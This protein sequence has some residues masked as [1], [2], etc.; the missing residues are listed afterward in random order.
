M[1]C[2]L[3]DVGAASRTRVRRQESA[4][5]QQTGDGGTR[6]GEET[7]GAGALG[8]RATLVQFSSAFCQPCR[9]T[10]RI[11]R[12]VSGM[13][14]GVAHAEIDA[15]E[16]L[17]L[18]RELGIVRTPAVLVLDAGGREVSR[19]YGQP[20]K[21]DVIAALAPAVE[22]GSGDTGSADTGG[23]AGERPAGDTGESARREKS[24]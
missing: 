8:R 3:R 18:V 24:T 4:V 5:R 23:A 11:L 10:R 9:A 6:L 22:A 17:A 12:E 2:T 15:E 7:L 19:A 20:R 14:P 21:A 1:C 13:V 16:R